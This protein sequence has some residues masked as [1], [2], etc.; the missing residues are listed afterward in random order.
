M[1]T[2]T[3]Y[4]VLSETSDKS[5]TLLC[6]QRYILWQI[7][8][9]GR[10]ILIASQE[11]SELLLIYL[12]RI[13]RLTPFVNLLKDIYSLCHNTCTMTSVSRINIAQEIILINMLHSMH[14]VYTSF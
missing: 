14:G 2:S 6:W 5:G 13:A 10:V 3:R 8:F 12:E 9:Y 1:P 4:M 11:N 7:I